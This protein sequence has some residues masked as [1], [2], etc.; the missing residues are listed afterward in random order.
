MLFVLFGLRRPYRPI[1]TMMKVLVGLMVIGFLGNLFFA[2]PSPDGILGGLLPSLPESLH[3][4]LVP[5]VVGGV[6]QDAVLP[7]Q[8]LVGTTFSVAAAFYQAYLV[9]ERG[10]KRAELRAGLVDS[11]VG[12][13]VLGLLS[14]TILVTAAAVLHGSVAGG[15][16]RSAADVAVQLEPLFGPWAKVLFSLGLLAAALSSFLIN[17]MIGGTVL[18]DSLGLGGDLGRPMPKVFTTLALVIGLVVAISVLEGHSPVQLILFAQAMT[19]L[20]NPVLAGVMLWM[21]ARAKT[22]RWIQGLA[23]LGFLVV[24]VLALRTGYRLWLS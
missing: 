21:S 9:R 22:P 24:L 19:V 11:L 17:A 4:D 16:L 15:D 6:L 14:A 1:E 7:L 10:W 2:R 12:I 5:R 13:S 18:S 20:G 8:A 3:A 23:F